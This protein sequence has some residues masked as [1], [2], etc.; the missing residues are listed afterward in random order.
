MRLFFRGVGGRVG[1]ISCPLNQLVGGVG[2]CLRVQR[3]LSPPLRWD[4]GGE[5]G[6]WLLSS[7]SPSLRSGRVSVVVS[8]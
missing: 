6:W 5:G 4:S 8:N 1:S 3:L 7:R 2:P